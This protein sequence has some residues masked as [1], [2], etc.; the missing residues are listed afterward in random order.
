MRGDTLLE[1]SFGA[2]LREHR[3]NA[4]LTQEQLAAR[5]SI[6]SQAIG[7]LE[8]GT[9]RFPHQYTV[10]RLADALGLDGEQR[11]AFTTAAARPSVPVADQSSGTTS[12]PPGTTL[13]RQLPPPTALIGRDAMAAEIVAEL[14]RAG[15]ADAHTALLVGPGGIGKTTAALA[16]GHLLAEEFADGQLFADLRG[17]HEEPVDPHVVLGRFLRAL[18]MPPAQV[19]SD[20]D[21]RLAAYR[22]LLAGRRL[23]LVLD[24]AAAEEQVR[25]LLPPTGGSAVIVTSRR[26]LGA[27]LGAARWTV[28]ALVREE[29]VRLLAR[30]A[31]AARIAAE[32]VAAAQVA[33]ACGYS[34]LAICVAGGR[35]AARPDW[36]VAE[37]GRRLTAEHGRLDALS[38][39]D[40]DV[41]ASIGLSYRLLDPVH[42]ALLRRLAVL[43]AIDW[44]AWVCDE[45]TGRPAQGPLDA[46]VGVH[47]V[48]PRGVDGAG[49]ARY[50]LH[51]LVR[52]FAVERAYAEDT[53][54]DR[55][56]AVVRVLRAWLALASA[57]DGRRGYGLQ[58]AA[59]LQAPAVPDSAAVAAGLDATGWFEAERTNLVAAVRHACRLGHGDLAAELALWTSGFL[60]SRNYAEDHEYALEA[61]WAAVQDDHLR[62]R[63]ALALFSAYLTSDRDVDMPAVLVEARTLA[64][65]LGQRDLEVRALLQSG[66]YAKRRG[67]LVEAIGWFEQA[68]AACAD[69]SPILLVTTSLHNLAL[70]YAEAGR[71]EEGIPL[72]ERAVA[73]QRTGDAPAMTA[74]RLLGQA[75]VLVD[76]GR[77]E[78]AMRSLTESL[79]TLETVGNEAMVTYGRL[80]LG[81]LAVRQGRFTD[82]AALL[83][84]CLEHF[85][86]IGDHAS[87]ALVLRSLGDLALVREDPA[88][89]VEP[90]RRALATWQHLGFALEAARVHYRLDRALASLGDESAERHRAECRR[91]LAE[92]GLDRACLRLPPLP[93]LVR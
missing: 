85:E 46:L 69:D 15:S 87:T 14:R 57:A 49:Q 54:R 77:H 73:I 33:D 27:L 75:D 48:E 6:S 23:L 1:F 12:E 13:P 47:M 16:V 80:K 79:Y 17:A 8:R 24:D 43:D 10:T 40:L 55:E 53:H 64:R 67:R 31:G 89:A 26:H 38:V 22:S 34:P 66:A 41:R 58:H 88:E 65:R 52:E 61:A 25:P 93:A 50:G 9:R 90:L 3:R 60:K 30:I 51:D 56:E 35:L 45:L 92:L 36:K 5:A 29:A 70:A 81:D 72:I 4:G 20:P 7:A 63:V 71:P 19:P 86:R 2:L 32:P 44:P 21:E 18:G 11:A 76:A 68:I 59:G 37:L 83:H 84:H 28:P 42:R 62:L 74:M 82:A 91:I 78:E 39:G